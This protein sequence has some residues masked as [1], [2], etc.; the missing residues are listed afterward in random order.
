MTDA[1]AEFLPDADGNARVVLHGGDSRQL[2]KALALGSIDVDL[3]GRTALK[4]VPRA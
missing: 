4:I 2:V 3:S 1:P